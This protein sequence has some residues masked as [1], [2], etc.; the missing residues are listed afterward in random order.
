MYAL[1]RGLHLQYKTHHIRM[2]KLYN[3]QLYMW[4]SFLSLSKS[5]YVQVVEEVPGQENQWVAIL[6]LDWMVEDFLGSEHQVTT[7]RHRRE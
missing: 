5:D 4:V 3:H 2:C 1:L 7:H 6:H